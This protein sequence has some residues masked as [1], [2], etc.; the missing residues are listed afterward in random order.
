P[1]AQGRGDLSGRTC[2]AIAS[3]VARTARITPTPYPSPQGGR[4]FAEVDSKRPC[5]LTST[6]VEVSPPPCG[7]GQGV[8]VT[9]PEE[10]APPRTDAGL[11]DAPCW[12]RRGG[13]SLESVRAFFA[14]HAPDI[15]ILVTEQSSA[16]VAL[17]AQA[18]GVAPEQIAK[19]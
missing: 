2:G 19:T 4:G 1:P 15:D 11:P 13:M 9:P 6:S 8:G 5:V 3:T 12:V 10:T 14:R 17:A 18:H 16:T 7:E